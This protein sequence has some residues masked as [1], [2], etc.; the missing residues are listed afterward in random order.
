MD[1]KPN[2]RHAL[3]PVLVWAMAGP[4]L[5][6]VSVNVPL[7]HWAY[8]HIDRLVDYGLIDSAML[9]TRPISR[10]EMARLI[11]QALENPDSSKA[12]K[13]ISA[14]LK[15]L[16]EEFRCELMAI[17]SQ[18]V[19]GL[20][21]HIKPIEDP[22]IEI[23]EASRDLDLENRSGD[24]Y[25]EG[26]N[27]R[28]GFASRATLFERFG[29]YVHPEYRSPWRT[30]VHTEVVEGYAKSQ[31]GPVEI[32]VGK[33]S[34][35]WGPGYHGSMIIG[36]NAQN[37]GMLKVSTPQPIELPWFLQALGPFKA[38]YFLAR[39]ESDRDRPHARL[40]GLRM[41]IKPRPWLELGGSR[42]IMFGGEGVPDVGLEDYLAIFWPKNIQGFEDQRA[43]LDATVWLSMPRQIPARS[44]K[45]YIEWAGEDAAG[46]S[47]YVPLVGLKVNDILRMGN[48][49]LRIEYATTHIDGF[50]NVFYNHGFYYSG[51]TYHGRVLGHHM[52]TDSKDTFL[53]LDHCITDQI[54]LGLWYDLQESNLSGLPRPRLEQYGIDLLW[55][56]PKRWQVQ[57]GYRWQDLASAGPTQREHVLDMA[58]I[59]NF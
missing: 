12:D 41:S 44:V 49:D 35:W 2:R 45:A 59:Y 48:T 43:S 27:I 57:V 14:S 5:G 40:T 39:L 3:I 50:P 20:I 24:S 58:L 34:I 31:I 33:D 7:S 28:M 26:T 11:Q 21:D 8:Q 6:T 55:F 15:R 4:C 32:E 23:V 36:N 53:R 46:F 42:T 25:Q 38:V 16:E 9:A 18:R 13:S 22:Y 52:G 10:M 29:F 47:L 51:Y 1:G 30:D 54:S 56:A 17:S 19:P 37:L